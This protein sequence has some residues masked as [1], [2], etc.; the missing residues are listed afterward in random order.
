MIS[1]TLICLISHIYVYIYVELHNAS[2]INMSRKLCPWI[3]P[4]THG[5]CYYNPNP[6][7]KNNLTF[8]LLQLD[9]T[10]FALEMA[11]HINNLLY[12]FLCVFFFFSSLLISTTGMIKRYMI[13]FY[14]FRLDE[15]VV[16]VWWNLYVRNIA[17]KFLV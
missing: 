11:C 15:R 17:Y 9:P 6:S 10:D 4:F 8:I 14:L 5:F 1:F 7:Q 12:I 16:E 2:F 3:F 13:E